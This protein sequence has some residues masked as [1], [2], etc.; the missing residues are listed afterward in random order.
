MSLCL[1]PPLVVT[2]TLHSTR[3]RLSC[4]PWGKAGHRK[5]VRDV[6]PRP[7]PSPPLLVCF[8]GIPRRRFQA[9]AGRPQLQPSPRASCGSW[10]TSPGMRQDQGK[11]HSAFSPRGA[12]THPLCV[13]ISFVAGSLTCRPGTTQE[14]TRGSGP[15]PHTGPERSLLGGAGARGDLESGRPGLSDPP[16]PPTQRPQVGAGGGN[17]GGGSRL[18]LLADRVAGVRGVVPLCTLRHQGG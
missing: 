17:G 3:E 12:V 6:S 5:G 1:C 7:S 10:G 14:P 16:H 13:L 4:G 18:P 8:S 15:P 9:P 2:G 11:A